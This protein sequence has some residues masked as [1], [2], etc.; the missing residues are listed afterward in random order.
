MQRRKDRVANF[1]PTLVMQPMLLLQFSRSIVQT[2]LMKYKDR[3]TI[4]RKI[5]RSKILDKRVPVDVR[6]DCK[7]HYTSTSSQLSDGVSTAAWK[8]RQFVASMELVCM[9][10]ASKIFIP[11]SNLLTLQLLSLRLHYFIVTVQ[12]CKLYTDIAI[13]IVGSRSV[14]MLLSLVGVSKRE[15]VHFN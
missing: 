13:F 5:G 7:E 2:Y 4:G 9:I 12:V 1:F 8:P 11:T 3:E 14:F 6:F 15:V 10:D